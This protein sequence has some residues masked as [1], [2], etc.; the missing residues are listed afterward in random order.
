MTRSHQLTI[1]GL[2][3]ELA[4]RR[5]RG[6]LVP[7]R[8]PRRWPI[9]LAFAVVFVFLAGLLWAFGMTVWTAYAAHPRVIPGCLL[10]GL[11]VVISIESWSGDS[12]GRGGDSNQR[13]W[14]VGAGRAAVRL[15]GALLVAAGVL[16][17]AS[18]L[19]KPVMLV[20]LGTVGFA[21]AGYLLVVNLGLLVAWW[22]R[23]MRWAWRPLLVTFGISTLVSG[24]AFRLIF[25]EI[26]G[27][28]VL[29]R[30]WQYQLLFF[31]MG[32]SAF[33]WTWL[34]FAVGAFRA[35]V[36]ALEANPAFGGDL[37]STDKLVPPWRTL[38]Q[39]LRPVRLVVS[40]VVLV[41]A[42]RVF[43]AVLI[44]VP[45]SMQDRVQSATV[46]WWR[47]ATEG[48]PG[49]A[50]AQ[51]L[52]LVVFVGCVAWW[53]QRPI[54]TQDRSLT[55]IPEPGR[56][57]PREARSLPA[58]AT[59]GLVLGLGAL[60]P[61]G[62]LVWASA[63]GP[64][65]LGVATLVETL[66]D[67]ALRRALMTTAEVAVVA[68][69]TVVG[70]AVPVAYQLA[71]WS[72]SHTLYWRATMVV[73]VVLAVLPVQSYLGSLDQFFDDSGLSGTRLPLMTVHVAAGLPISILILRGALLSPSGSRE[74]DVLHGLGMR[75][76]T[77]GRIWRAAGPALI[78][79]AVLEFVQVWNDFVVG[80]IVNG[81]GASPWSLLLWGEARQ[82]SENT[83]QLAAGALLSS[84]APVALVLLTWRRWLLPGL[85]GKVL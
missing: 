78:A 49:A 45:G 69:V 30:L 52:P 23:G 57:V 80:L 13:S 47:L 70:L 3:L 55:A 81:A 37:P 58:R 71:A 72:P 31:L 76:P 54:R 85:I 14:R 46:Q 56:E 63:N 62:V 84:L 16:L 7:G 79:V 9:W 42:G 60:T 10:A 75:A 74:A 4:P 20:Y 36:R 33:V 64:Q 22:T 61:I 50:A 35:G 6:T 19:H 17:V 83:G 39:R 29:D 11:G 32:L 26:G 15:C 82:F 1:H 51:S 27:W 41:A 34:G 40:L 53:A 12:R 44:G 66:S 5:M 24:V 2:E 77:L 28:L 59:M 25:Q 21:G 68:T 73:L 8:P 67:D 65:G 48:E 18:E 38:H 43:D